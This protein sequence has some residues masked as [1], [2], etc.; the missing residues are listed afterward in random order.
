MNNN[1]FSIIKVTFARFEVFAA[2]KI[3]VQ[4]L[5]GCDHVVLQ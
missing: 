3:Q 5:L 1:I 4:G 2:A